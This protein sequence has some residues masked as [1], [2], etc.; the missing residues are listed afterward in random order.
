MNL[1]VRE[2]EDSRYSVVRKKGRK[3]QSNFLHL[4]FFQ[5]N[6]HFVFYHSFVCEGSSVALVT[7]SSF[8]L[9]QPSS[10]L[11]LQVQKNLLLSPTLLI[12]DTSMCDLILK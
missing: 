6:D 10:C 2:A 9:L 8:S 4:S 3:T 12:K 1:L 11:I 5:G 7:C